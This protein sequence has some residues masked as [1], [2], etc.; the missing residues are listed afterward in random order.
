[1]SAADHQFLTHSAGYTSAYYLASTRQAKCFRH[2]TKLP[3]LGHMQRSE[4]QGCI[5]VS[6][7]RGGGGSQAVVLSKFK[8]LGMHTILAPKEK[9]T[10]SLTLLK[11]YTTQSPRSQGAAL[12]PNFQQSQRICRRKRKERLT[13]DSPLWARHR[14]L[15]TAPKQTDWMVVLHPIKVTNTVCSR[16]Q[17]H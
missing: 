1:M 3:S 10:P 9:E 7:A 14:L 5:T 4:A 17:S 13:L 2:H 8:A 15:L 11:L 6:Q 12:A 16:G